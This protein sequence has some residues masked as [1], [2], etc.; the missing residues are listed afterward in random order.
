V[1]SVASPAIVIFTFLKIDIR[2]ACVLYN[3]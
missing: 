1:T 2:I 3:K